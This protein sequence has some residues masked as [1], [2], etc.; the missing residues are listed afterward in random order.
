MSPH[1]AICT[2]LP[3]LTLLLLTPDISC[4]TYLACVTNTGYIRSLGTL[5]KQKLHR[6][7]KGYWIIL[8]I[9]VLPFTVS[10]SVCKAHYWNSN[11][12]LWNPSDLVGRPTIS[13][14]PEDRFSHMGS[15][16]TR[17]NTNLKQ[18]RQNNAIKGNFSSSTCYTFS[19]GFVSRNVVGCILIVIFF[20]VYCHYFLPEKRGVVL[21]SYS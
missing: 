8:D 16:M 6:S 2:V 7:I 14:V 1:C 15:S 3:W 13:L 11:R 20:I 12:N 19:R 4:A 17:V 18:A 5:A 9:K 21:H 10:I